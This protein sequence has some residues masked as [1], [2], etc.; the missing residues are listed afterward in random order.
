MLI[1]REKTA[2][3][4]AGEIPAEARAFETFGL[5]CG[6]GGKDPVEAACRERGIAP[7]AAVPGAGALWAQSKGRHQ[8]VE[9]HWPEL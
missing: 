6:C 2:G 9:T 3:E 5:D 7:R 4:I 1:L 8:S